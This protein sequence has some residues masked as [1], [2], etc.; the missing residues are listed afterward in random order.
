MN[1][2][3]NPLNALKKAFSKLKKSFEKCRKDFLDRL[4][5]NEQL[6]DDDENWLDNN[7]N[8]V[9]E[10]R[11]IDTLDTA[12]DFKRGLERL[13]DEE[14]AALQ[15]LRLAAG[16]DLSKKRK[17]KCIIQRQLAVM[18]KKCLTSFKFQ[19][20]IQFE[21]HH[22]IPCQSQILLDRNLPKSLRFS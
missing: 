1:Q 20:L 13:S 5:K 19:V 18:L 3:Q 2:P 12:S 4:A 21:N 15:R 17:R 9:N 16:L 14:K 10:Q 22:K 11:V 6:S 7:G 8:L